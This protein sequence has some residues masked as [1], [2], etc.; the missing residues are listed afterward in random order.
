MKITEIENK[1]TSD[2]DHNKHIT[3][4]EFTEL[5]PENFTAG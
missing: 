4:Q 2:P 3:I 1:I 5:P